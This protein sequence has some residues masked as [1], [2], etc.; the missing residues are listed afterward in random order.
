MSTVGWGES[1]QGERKGLLR[2]GA[3][4]WEQL[5]AKSLLGRVRCLEEEP[6]PRGGMASPRVRT[7]AR[8]PS[9]G[10]GRRVEGCYP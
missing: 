1:L 5:S 10:A 4:V 7:A 9:C 8:K 6:S 3:V 2:V